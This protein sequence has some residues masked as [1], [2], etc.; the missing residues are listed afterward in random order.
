MDQQISPS[1]NGHKVT[2][3]VNRST[4]ALAS[5]VDRRARHKVSSRQRKVGI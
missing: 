2:I 1:Y 4:E 3:Q 5:T